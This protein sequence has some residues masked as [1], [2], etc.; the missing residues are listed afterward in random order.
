M[1]KYNLGGKKLGS[2]I[3]ETERAS[4]RERESVRTGWMNTV[5]QL[6]KDKKTELENN[7]PT[8]PKERNRIIFVN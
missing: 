2:L 1:L 4:E 7:T 5:S 8:E 6:Q 3:G